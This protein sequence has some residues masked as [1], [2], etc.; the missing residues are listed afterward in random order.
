MDEHVYVERADPE[1][2]GYEKGTRRYNNVVS[3]YQWANRFVSGTVVDMPCGMGWGT[4]YISN[5]D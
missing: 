2:K 1:A 4:S 5:A 3:R